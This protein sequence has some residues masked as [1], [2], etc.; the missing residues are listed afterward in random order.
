VERL[1]I[2]ELRAALGW[3]AAQTAE[4]FVVTEATVGPWIARLEEE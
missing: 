4:R 3:S 2:V 1:A